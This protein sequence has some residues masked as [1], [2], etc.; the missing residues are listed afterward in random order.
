MQEQA[1][2]L[3]ELFKHEEFAP[4]L[5]TPM[6]ALTVPELNH[7]VEMFAVKDA[8]LE[9]GDDLEEIDFEFLVEII[10]KL[11]FFERFTKSTRTKILKIATLKLVPPEE[12]IFR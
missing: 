5:R 11:P 1:H 4:W 7:V 12:C 3:E 6:V 2:F 8:L 9:A 10:S